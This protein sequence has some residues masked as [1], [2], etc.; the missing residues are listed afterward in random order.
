[1]RRRIVVVGGR[2]F[3]GSRAVEALRRTD[4]FEVLVAGRSGPDL[5]LDLGSEASLAALRG[6]AVVVNVS[7]SHAAPP[8]LLA[9][10]ALREGLVYVEATS[11]RTVVERL[12]SKRAPAVSSSGLIVLGA[13]IYTG[14]SNLLGGAAAR[15]CARV[16]SLTIGIRSSP[17]SGAGQG[18]IDLMVDAMGVP[19][20]SARSGDLVDETAAMPGPVVPYAKKPRWSLKFSFPEVPMLHVSTGVPD[21]TLGFSPAPSFLWPTFRFLPTWVM[22]ASWFRKLLG[23]YFK[24]IRRGLLSSHASEVELCAVAR[25]DGALVRRTLVA[26]DGMAVGGAAIAAIAVQLARH[27]PART[28]VLTVDELLDLDETLREIRRLSPEAAVRSERS[29]SISDNP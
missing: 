23:L 11:D 15:E 16:Q 22:K 29:E 19:A 13:G 24:I 4:E 8:D 17:F 3:L 6:A 10:F 26:A 28:G 18:T 21:V 12:L 2:G 25:G 5:V 7:S 9:A 1:M 20:R 27:Q 14:L